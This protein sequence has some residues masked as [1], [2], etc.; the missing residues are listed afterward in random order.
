[1]GRSHEL[2]DQRTVVIEIHMSCM[3][4]DRIGNQFT[5][6]YLF[7]LQVISYCKIFCLIV[8]PSG[9]HISFNIGSILERI[10]LP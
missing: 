2:P 6:F 5:L 9:R 7:Q 1:M 10:I 8:F 3:K 4:C